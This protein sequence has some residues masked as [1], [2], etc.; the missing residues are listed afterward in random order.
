MTAALQRQGPSDEASERD[1]LLSA[2]KA[3]RDLQRKVGAAAPFPWYMTIGWP[4][5]GKSSALINSGLQFAE[6]GGLPEAPAGGVQYRMTDEAILVDAPGRWIGGDGDRGDW[7]GFLRL[8]KRSRPAPALNGVLVMIAAEELLTLSAEE[9]TRR[10]KAIRQR[11]RDLDDVL[12]VNLPVYLVFTRLDRLAGFA[13]FFR[14]LASA[15]REQVLGATLPEPEQGRAGPDPAAWL[16]EAVRR[17]GERLEAAELDRLASERDPG[18]RVQIFVFPRQFALL[19]ERVKATIGEI[20]ASSRLE[21][22]LRL[23]G[24]YFASARQ[25]GYAIDPLG[26]ATAERFGVDLPL[27]GGGRG[28]GGFF[29]TRLFKDVVFVEQNVVSLESG[30]G[31][32]F[33]PV[34]A[35]VGAILAVGLAAFWLIVYSDQQIRLANSD[36]RLAAYSAQAKAIPTRD[37]ADADL[38]K[39]ARSLDQVR[40]LGKDWSAGALG[41]LAFD[42][43]AKLRPAVTD[44]YNRGLDL[45]LAPRIFVGLQ[46]ELQ[47]SADAAKLYLA[48]AGKAP[49]DKASA[50]PALAAFFDRRVKGVDGPAL[51]QALK[52]H[53]EALLAKRLAPP[54]LDEIAIEDAKAKAAA[55]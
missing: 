55:P 45:T 7:L 17:L 43:S 49:L 53:A 13:G 14:D 51:R 31:G 15:G 30:G 5:A 48:L 40:D 12:A 38:A 22:P 34:L 33:R 21:R 8:L 6:A 20:A 2:L 41:F 46:Q 16:D 23:R 28:D 11:L 42:Q 24:A 4:G 44:L 29:L 1:R 19:V 36:T 54:T 27:I 25:D 50:T 9:R 10:A 39:A 3:A 18:R 35:A 52:D 26:Q 37:I 47:S 32:R